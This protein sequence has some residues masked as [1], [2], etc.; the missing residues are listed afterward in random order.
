MTREKTNDEKEEEKSV[1]DI[2]IKSSK[3]DEEEITKQLQKKLED[4]NLKDANNDG[5]VDE[6]D[7]EIA[8][9]KLLMKKNKK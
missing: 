2:L 3:I 6:S 8:K 4:G 1:S 5:V 7:V 9:N